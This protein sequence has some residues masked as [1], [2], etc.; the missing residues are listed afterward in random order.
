MKDSRYFPHANEIVDD[1]QAHHGGTATVFVNGVRV[2]TNVLKPDGSRAIGTTLATGP[3]YEA[4]RAGDAG[5]GFAVVAQEVRALAQ[6]SAEAAKE[7]KD[8]ISTSSKQ[9]EEGVRLVGETDTALNRISTQVAEISSVITNI[10]AATKEQAVGL[11]EVN[12]AI[13]QMDQFTQQNAAMVEQSSAAGQSLTHE[14]EK[15]T[16]LIGRFQIDSGK[17]MA[18]SRKAVA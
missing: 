5:R 4:A 16:R 2:A 7:I 6:R 1:V 11:A 13:N 17:A 10:A 8:L 14:T 12:T 9:V 3:A 18:V 15:L